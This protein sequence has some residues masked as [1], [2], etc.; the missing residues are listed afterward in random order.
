MGL[1]AGVDAA[2]AD[3]LLVDGI[4]GDTFFLNE[5]LDLLHDVR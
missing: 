4:G 3:L 2:L 1:E 5:L